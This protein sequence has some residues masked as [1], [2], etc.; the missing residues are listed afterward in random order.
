MVPSADIG[1]A[2]SI[3]CQSSEVKLKA[4]HADYL[5]RCVRTTCACAVDYKGMHM[6]MFCGILGG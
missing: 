3:V 2:L 1:H 5:F 4:L 6:P